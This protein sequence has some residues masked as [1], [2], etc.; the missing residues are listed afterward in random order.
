MIVNR[1]VWVY[2]IET[3]ASFFS[4]C[5]INIDSLEKVS[6]VIHKSRNDYKQLIKFLLN[7]Q[8]GIG[9]NNINF[10]YPILHYMIN[11]YHN[12]SEAD[13]EVIIQLIYYEAQR[14]IETQNK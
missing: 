4:Y 5:A 10:D 3:L 14:I 8:G 1:R 11:N 2:D 6:F 9:F 12:L 13:P 7:T